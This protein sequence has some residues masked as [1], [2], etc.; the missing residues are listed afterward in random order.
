MNCENCGKELEDGAEAVAI[1]SGQISDSMAGFTP[2]MSEGWEPVLCPA[3][4]EIYYAAPQMA[5]KVAR[6]EKA[7]GELLAALEDMTLLVELNLPRPEE[8]NALRMARAAIAKARPDDTCGAHACGADLCDGCDNPTRGPIGPS[9]TRE[10]APEWAPGDRRRFF[11]DTA[12]KPGTITC[13]AGPGKGGGLVITCAEAERLLREHGEALPFDIMAQNYGGED[14][15]TDFVGLTT[16]D[17]DEHAPE[18]SQLDED[19]GPFEVWGS[20]ASTKAAPKACGYA[21]TE[22]HAQAVHKS[23]PAAQP[24]ATIRAVIVV[25]GN[26]GGLLRVVPV[27]VPREIWEDGEA[28]E[29]I[30]EKGIAGTLDGSEG[31]EV[32]SAEDALELAAKLADAAS[33]TLCLRAAE[34]P[35]IYRVQEYSE[36]RRFTGTLA[37]LDEIARREGASGPGF[38]SGQID[39]RMRPGQRAHIYNGSENGA[40]AHVDRIK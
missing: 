31:Y 30:D 34:P 29:W 4:A 1:T 3:C 32:M 20:I 26:G 25:T 28:R 7:Q 19:W 17:R 22:Q 39:S 14:E 11:T 8:N 12:G 33:A 40:I 24:A 36:G 6:L 10:A 2:S 16:E 38:F 35:A 5:E 18:G 15:G 37:A 21:G 23:G 27:D 13:E 9:A